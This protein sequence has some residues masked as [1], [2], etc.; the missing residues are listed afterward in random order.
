M[1]FR[2]SSAEQYEKSCKDAA[3]DPQKFWAEIADQIT[4]MYVC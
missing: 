2:I 4:K 3:M 1:V